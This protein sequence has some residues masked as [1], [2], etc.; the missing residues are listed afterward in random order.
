M[1][2]FRGAHSKTSMDRPALVTT[3]RRYIAAFSSAAIII[4]V[5]V[6]VAGGLTRVLQRHATI[7]RA[8]EVLG[9]K[10]DLLQRLTDAETGQRGYVIAGDSSYLQPFLGAKYDVERAIEKLQELTAS[11][12]AAAN[13]LRPL[14]SVVEERLRILD[15]RVAIRSRSG[16]D[17]ARAAIISGGG[18]EL[19]DSARLLSNRLE[20]QYAT[21]VT[22]QLAAQRREAGTLFAVVIIGTVLAAIVAVMLNEMLG[23][24][25]A[26]AERL[27]EQAE[28]ANRAKSAFLAMM[29]HDLRT[30]LNAIGGY[31]DLL[32]LGIGGELTQTQREYVERIRASNRFLLGLINDVLSFAKTEVGQLDMRLESVRVSEFLASVEPMVAPQLRAAELEYSA[33]FSCQTGD[34][35]ARVRADPEKLRQILLNLLTNAIKFTPKGGRIDLRCGCDSSMVWIA[36]R[37]TGRG[38]PPDMV[39]EV[40]KPF[41]QL[42]S[43]RH[44]QGGGG[45]GLGLAISRELARRMNGDIDVESVVGV[46]S[47]FT[48]RLPREGPESDPSSGAPLTELQRRTPLTAATPDAS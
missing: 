20:E 27:R 21:Q 17:S 46:G 22:E 30:P 45:V 12:A 40:F 9:A 4:V 25:A 13:V 38:I 19:M 28:A 34:C 15:E 36:V 5:G 37:D 39:Q 6:A 11:D 32:D 29:S 2:A 23:R 10:H 16:F 41:V 7:R 43:T 26:E 3:R 1:P 8:E 14:D 31:A 33:S 47:T 18:R 24:A 35:G 44:G 42:E 48:V